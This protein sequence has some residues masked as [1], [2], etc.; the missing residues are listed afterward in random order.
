MADAAILNFYT[1]RNWRALGTAHYLRRR[2]MRHYGVQS[3]LDGRTDTQTPTTTIP[4]P[5]AKRRGD[6]NNAAAG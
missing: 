5:L 6:G 4:S 3:R 2:L 1:K